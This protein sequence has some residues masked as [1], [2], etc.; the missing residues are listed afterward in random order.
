MLKRIFSI[1]ASFQIA[2]IL[3]CATNN[4]STTAPHSTLEN[5]NVE[6]QNDKLATIQ[7]KKKPLSAVSI[8]AFTKDTQ[9]RARISGDNHLAMVWWIPNEFWESV[10]IRNDSLSDANKKMMLDVMAGISIL[11]VVQADVTELG[12]FTFFSKE[13]I[14]KHMTISFYDPKETLTR[15]TPIQSID[16]NLQIVLGAF[17]PIL[18]AAMGNLGKNLHFYVL[19]DKIDSFHRLMD[20]YEK[21]LIKIQL[22]KNENVPISA[23]IE[24]PLNCLYVPRKC[25]NG[26]DAHI[27]W[28]YC[29]WTGEKL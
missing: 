28:R 13:S 18:E 10:L 12:A 17:K 16:S 8:E 27:T 23:E 11:G 19:N 6:T 1:A 20:P 24:L 5:M 15:I 2:F 29:P 21:G 3:S 4:T 26:K 25:P 7:L 22:M 14:L 9:A